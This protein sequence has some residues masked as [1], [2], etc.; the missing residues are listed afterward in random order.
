MD[1]GN[2]PVD[3]ST[4]CYDPISIPLIHYINHHHRSGYSRKL[5]LIVQMLAKMIRG[6]KYVASTVLLK[7]MYRYFLSR[8]CS[9]CTNRYKSSKT[10]QMPQKIV[11]W[12]KEMLNQSL[13]HHISLSKHKMSHL[14]FNTWRD[15]AR[16]TTF[17]DF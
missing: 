14:C 7:W 4:V 2:S 10:I 13:L 9:V 6:R 5:K 1:C 11:R 17:W 3:S 12:L 16:V 15:S 8:S